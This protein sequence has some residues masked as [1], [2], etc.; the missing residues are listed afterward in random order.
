LDRIKRSRSGARASF[1]VE[2]QVVED[3]ATKISTQDRQDRGVA[4][5]SVQ[6]FNGAR[7]SNNSRI[8]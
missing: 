2:A 6:F 5:R 7:F 8:S 1:G 4:F 3:A